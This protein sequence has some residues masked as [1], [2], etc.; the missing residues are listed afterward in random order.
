MSKYTHIFLK[1]L[2]SCHFFQICSM[3]VGWTSC[4]EKEG[5][6][7][8]VCFQT[9]WWKPKLPKHNETSMFTS[10]NLLCFSSPPHF[11]EFLPL[12]SC[13]DKGACPIVATETGGHATTI[14]FHSLNLYWAAAPLLSLT[15]SFLSA[16]SPINPMCMQA[17]VHTPTPKLPAQVKLTETHRED[18]KGQSMTQI[19]SKANMGVW[20][21]EI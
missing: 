16:M 19:Q 18:Q 17:H 20:V 13:F 12:L 21:W 14:C 11:R 3:S 7:E 2:N 9:P 10:I 4:L 8:Q 5:V 15:L 1:D 6:F